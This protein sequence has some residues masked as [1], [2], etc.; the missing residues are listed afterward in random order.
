MKVPFLTVGQVDSVLGAR[1]TAF[2]SLKI[3]EN[4]L[5]PKKKRG[6]NG[7]AR[8]DLGSS[9]WY[10]INSEKIYG[11]KK[12]LLQLSQC[13]EST[14][15]NDV[16]HIDEL[17]FGHCS[18]CG[19]WSFFDEFENDD[20]ATQGKLPLEDDEDDEETVEVTKTVKPPFTYV[21]TQTVTSADTL[22]RIGPTCRLDAEVY[23]KF[24][25][26]LISWVSERIG[27]TARDG[28]PQALADG[29]FVINVADEIHNDAQVKI[30]VEVGTGMVIHRL[31][32]IANVMEK[33]FSTTNQKVVV[34]CA[35]G[36]ERSVLAIVYFMATKWGMQ[37]QQ[38]LKQVQSKRPIALD[39]LHWIT[40]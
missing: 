19:E 21:P 40:L 3:W 5:T 16:N 25:P 12:L 1:I 22:K 4:L 37:L 32:E 2:S 13:C 14:P 11:G 24:D 10:T 35:M 34:H 28:V 8:V 29:H 27:V 39:R 17:D 18:K 36:M 31:N 23:N 26:K 38:A 20:D 30:P 9:I 6:E 15:T 33:V 7:D